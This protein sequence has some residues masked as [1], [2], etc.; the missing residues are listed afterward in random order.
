[1]GQTARRSERNT[2]P[3]SDEPYNYPSFPPE[4]D[5]EHF[6]RFPE[7]V[8]VGTRA[9]DPDLTDLDTGEPVQLSEMTKQGITVLEFGS[10]T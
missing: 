10:L 8:K 5:V 3:G 6:Q 2:D 1:M 7:I 4:S 9:P